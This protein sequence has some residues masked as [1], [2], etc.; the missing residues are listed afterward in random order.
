MVTRQCEPSRG[1]GA[2]PGCQTRKDRTRALNTVRT[3]RLGTTLASSSVNPHASTNPKLLNVPDMVA[4]DK[5][6]ETPLARGMSDEDIM[7]FRDQQLHTGVSAHTVYRAGC[8]GDNL[9]L[10]CSFWRR[11]SGRHS[12]QQACVLRSLRGSS[13][14]ETVYERA[15]KVGLSSSVDGWRRIVTY[16]TDVSKYRR[17]VCVSVQLQYNFNQWVVKHDIY[18]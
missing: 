12:D 13:D 8:E 15:I 14:Y 7:I 16:V 5:D 4:A 18:S 2:D 9:S 3:V 11:A 6:V 10:S 1:C 17:S